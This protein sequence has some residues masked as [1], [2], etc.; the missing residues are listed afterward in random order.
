MIR[1]KIPVLSKFKSLPRGSRSETHHC[2]YTVKYTGRHIMLNVSSIKVGVCF[3]R[4][5]KGTQVN[6][7]SMYQKYGKLC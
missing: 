3:G 4:L 5:R 2:Q 1:D 7:F 6:I